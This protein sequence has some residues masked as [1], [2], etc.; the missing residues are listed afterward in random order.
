MVQWMGMGGAPAAAALRPLKPY[1][2]KNKLLDFTPKSALP[3]ASPF[4]RWLI[5]PSGGSD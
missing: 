1:M 2:F 3:I 4:S 5:H